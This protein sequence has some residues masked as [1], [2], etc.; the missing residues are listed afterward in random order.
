MYQDL[1]LRS[2]VRFNEGSCYYAICLRRASRAKVSSWAR[3]GH[4]QVLKQPNEGA[5]YRVG[6]VC[7]SE[8]NYAEALPVQGRRFPLRMFVLPEVNSLFNLEKAQRISGTEA[9]RGALKRPLAK[10]LN[11]QRVLNEKPPPPGR[12]PQVITHS[13]HNKSTGEAVK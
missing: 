13:S 10:E 8:G 11:D 2:Y 4:K 6:G 12:R 5:L 9:T 1:N 7:Q 3:I